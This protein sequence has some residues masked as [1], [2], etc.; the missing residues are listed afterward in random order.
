MTERQIKEVRLSDVVSHL[1]RG[2]TRFTEDD[3]GFGSIQ[4]A[5]NLT[6]SE[7]AE[8]FRNEKIRGMRTRFPRLRIIDDLDAPNEAP[9]PNVSV[10]NTGADRESPGR[11]VQGE[12]ATT[13]LEQIPIDFEDE[14]R[15]IASGLIERRGALLS[16]NPEL[17]DLLAEA[18]LE[19]AQREGW[20]PTVT[21]LGAIAPMAPIAMDVTP[22]EEPAPDEGETIAETIAAVRTRRRAPRGTHTA[23]PFVGEPEPTVTTGGSGGGNVEQALTSLVD[24][25]RQAAPV[26][27]QEQAAAAAV[28]QSISAEDDEI[29]Q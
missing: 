15:R 3:R 10:N 16:G 25:L 27:V 12:D 11:S 17:R 28:E 22:V 21:G 14:T 7:V 1:H 4:Q 29:F 5:F 24:R 26:R 19:P 23:S 20:A 8:L 9:S 13:E 18:M 2:F 6:V